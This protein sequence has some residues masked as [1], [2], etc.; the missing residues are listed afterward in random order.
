[1]VCG[2]HADCFFWGASIQQPSWQL[3]SL[4]HQQQDSD[5]LAVW[6]RVSAKLGLIFLAL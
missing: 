1:M 3:V 6:A 4:Y 5:G 2:C